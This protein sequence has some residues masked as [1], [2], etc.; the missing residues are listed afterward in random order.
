VDT[1]NKI[2]D[3]HAG[4]CTHVFA[5]ELADVRAVLSKQNPV[6]S[7]RAHDMSL[8]DDQKVIE[9]SSEDKQW[10]RRDEEEGTRSCTSR[11]I[12]TAQRHGRRQQKGG[13]GIELPSKTKAGQNG[14]DARDVGRLD[15]GRLLRDDRLDRDRA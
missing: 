9:T 10:T 14:R 15:F 3:T 11:R 5:G 12:N 1:N 2:H 7:Q 6:V 13:D 8:N 4:Q